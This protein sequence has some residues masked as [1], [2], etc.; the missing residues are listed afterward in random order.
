MKYANEIVYQ[1]CKGTEK[2]YS[3][4]EALDR[5]YLFSL[6]D[7]FVQYLVFCFASKISRCN[8]AERAKG[9]FLFVKVTGIYFVLLLDGITYN[10]CPI[11]NRTIVLPNVKK[12]PNV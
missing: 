9:P 10:I 1:F 7:S 5:S 11:K 2:A 3:C 6:R 8:I 12:Q 4:N